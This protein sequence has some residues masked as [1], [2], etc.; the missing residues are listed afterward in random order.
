M[1][2]SKDVWQ[3]IKENAG[4]LF[5]QRKGGEFTYQVYGRTIKPD[6]TNRQIPAI[7]IERGLKHVPFMSTTEVNRLGVQGPSYVY[8][9]LMDARIRQNDW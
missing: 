9:I 1:T 8:A 4:Q 2:S 6:R 5:R 3:R 7:D